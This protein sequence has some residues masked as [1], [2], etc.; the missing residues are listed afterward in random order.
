[1]LSE[2][3]LIRRLLP[4]TPEPAARDSSAV[5]VFE[6]LILNGHHA[7]PQP[8]EPLVIRDPVVLA[9]T[10]DLLLVAHEMVARQIRRLPV[11]RGA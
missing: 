6:L 7:A 11:H 1:M 5:E 9:P 10:D 4:A 2:G 8:I 3:D